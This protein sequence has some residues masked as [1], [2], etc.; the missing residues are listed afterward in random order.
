MRESTLPGRFSRLLAVALCGLLLVGVCLSASAQSFTFTTFE[1]PGAGTAS[2][3]GTFGASINNSG[4]STG[5]YVDAGGAQ[6]GYLRAHDG[7]ITTSGVVTGF[8]TVVT[9]TPPNANRVWHGFLWA[10]DSTF[11]TFDAPSAGY[12]TIPKSINT[13]GAITGYYT[14]ANSVAHGFLRAPDGTFT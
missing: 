7:T 5:Y 2:D 3:Q 8:Y 13:S 6:H 11:T 10:P 1:A 12:Q 9:G 4:V 14:D